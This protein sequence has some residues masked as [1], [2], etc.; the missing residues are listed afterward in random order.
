MNGIWGRLR[1]KPAKPER[2][3][4]PKALLPDAAKS[5]ASI[6][7]DNPITRPD[8]DTL[9]RAKF[10]R[11]FADRILALDSTEGVVVGVLGPWGSGKTSFVNLASECLRQSGV[12]VLEFNPW[13]F[14]GADQLVQAFFI[15]LSAQLKLRHDFAEIGTLVEDYGEA[16]SGLGWLPFVGPWIERGR[17]ATRVFAKL[18]ERRKKGIRA[19]HQKVRDALEKL[20]KPIVVIL[21]D[22]DRL[23]T[24][25]IRDVFKLVR[26]T[27]NFPKIIYVLAFDRIRVEQAL[28]EQG[29][30]GRDYLE[31]ILQIGID[32]PAVPEHVLISQVFKAIDGALAGIENPGR[33]DED[34]WPDVFM[35]VIRPLIRNMR[36]VRRYAAAIHGTVRDL[37]GQVALADALALEAIR[38]F[39]PDVFRSMHLA[40]DGLTNTQNGYGMHGDP[41]HLKAQIETLLKA[42]GDREEVVRALIQRLFP[43][44]ERHVGGT[45]YGGEWKNRWLRDRRVAHEDILRLYLERAMGE[46][47][48]SFTDAENAWA[49]MTDRE[50]FDSYL[51]SLPMERVQDVISSLEAYE[52][53]FGREHVLPATV[54]L[55]NL[56]PD[57]PERQLGMMDLDTR[58]VVGRVV[59]R[60]VRALKDTQVVE[61]AVREILP[62]VHSLSSKWELITDVGYREGAGHKLVSEDAAKAFEK[63]WRA[64]VRAANAETLGKETQ[65]LGTLLHTKK[66]AEADE[67]PLVIHDSPAVTR[68]LLKAARGEVRSQAMGSRAI[69]REPRLAWDSLIEL[70]GDEAI[71]RRRIEDLKA[72][73]PN[74]VGD[75]LELADKYLS[76][77]RPK[78]FDDD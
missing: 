26:L 23:T 59:Y 69:Q 46:R 19:T 72:S 30:P 73:E 62:H 17:A 44:A 7:A 78:D 27:A 2:G 12:A 41:P 60:L 61:A 39:L 16:F 29:I 63:E 34:S 51:R 52:D 64:S 35:E 57:L 31:K 1:R 4:T 8:E 75:L 21:D 15:E 49:R 47:L 28:G 48:Q 36:D 70:F 53:R 43:A 45:H 54:V 67:P 66:D 33:F 20:E 13:M 38:V 9:G 6:P 74:D 22:I 32:L 40:V 5:T 14:S 11:S 65:L 10:A 37:G 50:A 3:G 25:E 42:A 76:G 68:A 58:L 71:L 77:W 18:L 55:L 24:P 56:L